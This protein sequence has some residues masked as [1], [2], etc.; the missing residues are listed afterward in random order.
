MLLNLPNI[1][2][3]QKHDR[4]FSS[5][6]FASMLKP[7]IFEGTHYKRWQEKCILWLTAMHCYFLAEP[8]SVGP[9][10]QE[11]ERAWEHA[12]TMFKAAILSVL[13]DTIVDIYVPLQTRKAM[14]EALE[15]KYGVSD[16]STKLY[17]MEQFYDYRMVDDRPIVEQAHEIQALTKEHE[18][19]GC[20]LPDKFVADCIIVKLPPTW[21][22]FAT[23][24]KHKRQEFGIAEL[25]G[26]LDVEEKTRAKD[27]RGKRVGDWSSRAYL[28]QKNHP[29]PQK[30]KFQQELKQKPTTAVTPL[31]FKIRPESSYVCPES[32]HIEQKNSNIRNNAIYSGKY[33]YNNTY[34]YQ[35]T[36]KQ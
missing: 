15:A 29:K 19:F 34:N 32:P 22:N 13:G 28:V 3:I 2:T 14:W 1:L 23:S 30:K 25:I 8:R 33:I 9:H 6:G 10:T 35:S 11:E 26:S 31:A 36:R 21:T 12:D 27:V 4:Q 5:V 7:N 16:A 20:V 17:I 18:I 24:L